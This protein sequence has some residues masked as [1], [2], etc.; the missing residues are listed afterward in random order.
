MAKAATS[1]ARKTPMVRVSPKSLNNL[2]SA[3]EK[4]KNASMVVAEVIVTDFNVRPASKGLCDV[5]EWIMCTSESTP[6]PIIN[7]AVIIVINVV[8]IP[9]KCMIPNIESK[10]PIIKKVT[11]NP[12]EILLLSK[13]TTKK[14]V[15]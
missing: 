11:F 5:E 8:L 7:G 3:R 6:I 9:I 15:I 2:P 13:E 1:N 14:R 10:M 12:S 4:L